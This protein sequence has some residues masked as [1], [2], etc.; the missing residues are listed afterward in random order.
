MKDIIRSF[1]LKVPERLGEE[2]RLRLQVEREGREPTL[3]DLLGRRSL[4]YWT[5][6]KEAGF[7]SYTYI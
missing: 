6:S 5:N 4:Y 2:N 1:R 7:S 3:L